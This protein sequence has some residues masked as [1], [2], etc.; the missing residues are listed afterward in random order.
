MLE[1]CSFQSNEVFISVGSSSKVL[2]SCRDMGHAP[3]MFGLAGQSEC[4]ETNSNEILMEPLLRL[5]T[6]SGI[7]YC[8]SC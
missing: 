1:L 4:R 7:S 6:K 2:P 3:D 8:N 5:T